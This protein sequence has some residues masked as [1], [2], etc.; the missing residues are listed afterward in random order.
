MTSNHVQLLTP[1]RDQFSKLLGIVIVHSVMP[2]I[3][4]HRG[5]WHP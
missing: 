1:S 2:N 4:Q 3:D 5:A